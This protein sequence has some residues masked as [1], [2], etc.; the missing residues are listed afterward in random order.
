MAVTLK[1][2]IVTCNNPD[3]PTRSSSLFSEFLAIGCVKSARIR[4]FRSRVFPL[5]GIRRDT[6]SSYSVQ[7]RENT[8]QKNSENRHFLRSD[9]LYTLL[10]ITVM[11]PSKA[12]IRARIALKA[13]CLF[14]N[15][16]LF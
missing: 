11:F 8:D 10:K 7:M 5:L 16:L 9:Y 15:F 4:S 6:A 14:P 12:E 2:L 13:T 1:R 3:Y